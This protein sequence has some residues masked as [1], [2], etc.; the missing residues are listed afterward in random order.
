MDECSNEYEIARAI[1]IIDLWLPVDM[2]RSV[3]DMITIIREYGIPI[4]AAAVA[5]QRLDVQV[6]C[7]DYVDILYR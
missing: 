1:K 2:S 4:S 6:T 3:R 7:D 5:M